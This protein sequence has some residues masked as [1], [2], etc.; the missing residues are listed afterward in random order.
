MNGFGLALR[1]DLGRYHATP[2][3]SH[4]NDGQV[5]WPPSPWRLLRALFSASRVD[6]RLNAERASVDHGLELL[7]AA[8]PPSYVLAPSVGAHTRHYLPQL[9]LDK[10]QAPKR[11]LDALRAQRRCRAPGSPPAC[12]LPCTAGS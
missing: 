1:F 12:A 2:W 6:T 11:D 8:P 4:V 7:L 9:K 3:G 10:K 5:E